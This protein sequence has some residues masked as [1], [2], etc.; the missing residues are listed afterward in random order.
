MN[1]VIFGLQCID[2]F[3]RK[4]QMNEILLQKKK[5]N[6]LKSYIRFTKI[7]KHEIEQNSF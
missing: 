1:R 5:K 6:D 3:L 2:W 4:L 7:E